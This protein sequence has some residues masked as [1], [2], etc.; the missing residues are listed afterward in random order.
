MTNLQFLK[1]S[2]TVN[3][4]M[5]TIHKNAPTTVAYICGFEAIFD[6]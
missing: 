6:L 3:Y 5:D 4:S 2:P 1:V